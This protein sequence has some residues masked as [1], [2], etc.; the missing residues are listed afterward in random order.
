MIAFESRSMGT[1]LLKNRIIHSPTY[2]G[3]AELDGSAGPGLIEY[4]QRLAAGGVGMH[5]V[6]NSCVHPSGRHLARQVGIDCDERLP[7]LQR[8]AEA[9][10]LGGAAACIQISHCGVHGNKS[11]SGFESMGPSPMENKRGGRARAMTTAEIKETVSWFAAAAARAKKAGF[12][13]VQIHAGHGYLVSAFLSPY[14]NRRR[15]EYGGS[16]E[17]RARFL[18]EILDAV[19]EMTGDDYPILAKLN[20]EDGLGGGLTHEMMVE[21]A[22][23]LEEK[24][25]DA[26]ELTRG[27]NADA[28]PFR[29]SSQPVNPKTPGEEGYYREAAVKYKERVKVP[30]ILVGGFRSPEGIERVLRDGIA[31]FISMSRPVVREPNLVARWLEGDLSRAKCVSC[32]RCMEI[33]GTERGIFCPLEEK[34]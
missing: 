27:C 32:N 6:S 23:L 34:G 8:L 12:D 13:G 28:G 18:L 9:I 31:D 20:S 4:N 21:T 26:I 7:G 3:L 29:V 14:Y 15:D 16:V 11:V 2:E 19:R 10:H 25:I 22:L 1:L 30:L 24:G 17:G 5:I 33:L